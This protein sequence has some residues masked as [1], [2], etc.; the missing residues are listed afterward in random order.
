MM[1][2]W[3]DLLPLF[4]PQ[5]KFMFKPEIVV[6]T[7]LISWNSAYCPKASLTSSPL[8][9]ILAFN[10]RKLLDSAFFRETSVSSWPIAI[11]FPE[12]RDSASSWDLG[13]TR[14][15][16]HVHAFTRPSASFSTSASAAGSLIQSLLLM[17]SWIDNGISWTSF[18]EISFCTWAWGIVGTTGIDST[19]W[20]NFFGNSCAIT[21]SHIFGGYNADFS[22]LPP[23]HGTCL[24]EGSCWHVW[25]LSMPAKSSLEVAI[26]QG[27]KCSP[28]N[29]HALHLAKWS[30]CL[31]QKSWVLPISILGSE[32]AIRNGHGRL[33]LKQS[34]QIRW[35][36][37]TS[38]YFLIV[39]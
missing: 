25:F 6:G 38:F 33:E 24:N 28:P 29:A 22:A 17:T 4:I 32:K 18:G 3:V 19:A 16:V 12:A 5:A 31:L 23:S 34:Q 37:L 11:S 10:F 20:W 1:S 39:F 35:K 30:W 21:A 8:K 14:S 27:L 9:Q 15:Y 26:V 7:P 13:T 36:S 2:L